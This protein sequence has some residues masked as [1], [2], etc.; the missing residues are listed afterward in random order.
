MR[1]IVWSSDVCSSYLVFVVAAGAVASTAAGVI[2]AGW[3]MFLSGHDLGVLATVLVLSATVA[4]GAALVVGRAFRSSV[5]AVTDQ[6]EGL[7]SDL[8]RP[9]PAALVT[10]QLRRLA[11]LLSAAHLPLFTPPDPR[12]AYL[13]FRSVFFL[14]FCSL[15]FPFLFN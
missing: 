7:T 15:F 3:F 4:A 13:L 11:L 8:D 1:I 12:S 6:I 14:S 5:Q 2:V 9:A 10:G